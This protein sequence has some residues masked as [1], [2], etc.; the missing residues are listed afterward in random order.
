M[1]SGSAVSDAVGMGGSGAGEGAVMSGFTLLLA[2]LWQPETVA[3]AT[4]RKRAVRN[5]LVRK[6]F[7]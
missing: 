6:D 2:F 4:A 7:G 1:A 5:D 3:S